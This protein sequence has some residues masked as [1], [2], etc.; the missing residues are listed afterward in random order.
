MP[1]PAAYFV[2]HGITLLETSPDEDSDWSQSVERQAYNGYYSAQGIGEFHDTW[3]VPWYSLISTRKD[4]LDAN[5]R[6]TPVNHIWNH[7]DK[8]EEDGWLYWLTSDGTHPD[9][10]ANGEARKVV[11][12][13][14]D[15]EGIWMD[16][17]TTGILLD[18]LHFSRMGHPIEVR[19]SPGPIIENGSF[20]FMN[21]EG[22]YNTSI[23][24]NSSFSGPEPDDAV[25]YGNFFML[26]RPIRNH[27]GD[28]M[29][30]KDGDNS[31]LLDNDWFM[32]AAHGEVLVDRQSGSLQVGNRVYY[33]FGKWAI[34]HSEDYILA[35][36]EYHYNKGPYCDEENVPA[37]STFL[38]GGNGRCQSTGVWMDGNED[39][40]HPMPHAGGSDVQ[41][42]YNRSSGMSGW[43]YMGGFRARGFGYNTDGRAENN[44]QQGNFLYRKQ[45]G[46]RYA[47]TAGQ[48]MTPTTA[49]LYGGHGTAIVLQDDWIDDKIGRQVQIFDA[50]LENDLCADAISMRLTDPWIAPCMDIRLKGTGTRSLSAR[51]ITFD[52]NMWVMSTP[53]SDGA[54][55]LDNMVELNEGAAGKNKRSCQYFRDSVSGV[56]NHTCSTAPI[57]VR[58]YPT[59]SRS[60]VDL[61]VTATHAG[62]DQGAFRTTLKSNVSDSTSI[63]IM[64]YRGFPVPSN[65]ATHQLPYIADAYDTIICGE[66]SC[67]DANTPGWFPDSEYIAGGL[68]D[69]EFF[70]VVNGTETTYTALTRTGTGYEA[71]LTLSAP[72]TATA[73]DNVHNMPYC[74]SAPDKGGASEFCGESAVPDSL[75]ANT[76]SYNVVSN[77]THSLNVLLNDRGFGDCADGDFQL[78]SG[79]FTENETLITALAINAGKVDVTLANGQDSDVRFTYTIEGINDCGAADAVGT[80]VLNVLPVTSGTSE[81]VYVQ[82]DTPCDVKP[83]GDGWT[84]DVNLATDCGIPTDASGGYY[85]L[86]PNLSGGVL[87]LGVRSAASSTDLSRRYRG[88]GHAGYTSAFDTGAVVDI[89]KQSTAVGNTKMDLRGYF[90]N[91]ANVTWNEP[92][93]AKSLTCDS[94]WNTITGYTAGQLVLFHIADSFGQFSDIKFR[95]AAG[96][97]ETPTESAYYQPM[98]VANG[99][100]NIEYHCSAATGVDEL[101]ELAVIDETVVSVPTGGW[102]VH[103]ATMTGTVETITPGVSCP[104]DDGCSAYVVAVV[105]DLNRR[106]DVETEPVGTQA[107]RRQR[108]GC[109]F[110]SCTRC[111]RESARCNE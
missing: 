74:G 81:Q 90:T 31:V 95:Y 64:D 65:Y 16:Q 72:I 83:T 94:T 47:I 45:N 103:P 66:P 70:I 73:G 11:A 52:N 6:G 96:G 33:S 5:I 61:T 29:I 110:H 51:N 7:G 56:T 4:N 21:Q 105:T 23:T 37:T 67:S 78:K 43:F 76:D 71:N 99:S 41:V 49:K 100:G 106:A 88:V 28:A 46:Q 111:K 38:L 30:L 32:S 84:A 79:G 97:A 2:N 36:N 108:K 63:T 39:E 80:V 12:I 98:L 22:Y 85:Q 55:L 92:P 26:T 42:V 34:H 62:V 50:H 89:Y 109:V 87:Q 13:E 3:G 86:T 104:G 10:R 58:N 77:T 17:C 24:Y 35:L 14:R 93:T 19:N 82:L 1:V 57:T 68:P 75:I 15:A 27:R 40:K 48:I 18:G 44:L 69:G 107:E 8:Y 101:L 25:I 60:N 53:P 102:E 20:S 59:F 54:T 91:S 9:T